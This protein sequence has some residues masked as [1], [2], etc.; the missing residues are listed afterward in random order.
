[1]SQP[2]PRSALPRM[3]IDTAIKVDPAPQIDQIDVNSEY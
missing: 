1:V 2:Q 3:T